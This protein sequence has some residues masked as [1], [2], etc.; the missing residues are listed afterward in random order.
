[1]GRGGDVGTHFWPPRCLLTQSR[2]PFGPFR[3]S[4]TPGERPPRI[5]M[6]IYHR[7]R[8]RQA[9]RWIMWIAVSRLPRLLEFLVAAVFEEIGVDLI[10]DAADAIRLRNRPN[11]LG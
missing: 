1:M 3:G 2:H 8:H 4:R 6:T 10:P 5:K 7:S 9:P 11:S